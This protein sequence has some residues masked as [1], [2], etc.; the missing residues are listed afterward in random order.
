MFYQCISD[1]AFD[2]IHITVISALV[3]NDG[4][5]WKLLFKVLVKPHSAKPVR[6]G[7]EQH[8]VRLRV[9]EVFPEHGGITDTFD[10]VAI[11]PQAF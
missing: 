4:K 6:M 10:Q 2:S 3:N 11:K 7:I 5:V 9:A 8:Q 1:S